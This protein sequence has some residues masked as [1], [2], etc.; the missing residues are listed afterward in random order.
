MTP[1]Q[2][3]NIISKYSGSHN[4]VICDLHSACSPL[5]GKKYMC[6]DI[7]SKKTV[8]DFDAVK[9]KADKER[10]IESRKSVDAVTNT[11]SGKYLCFIELKSWDL[12]LTNKGTENKIRK[13]ASKYE[14]DLPQKLT[15]SISICKQICKDESAF[16]NCKIVF[17]LVTDISVEKDGLADIQANLSALAGSSS[18]L[19]KLCNELSSKIMDDIQGVET[20]YWN[21][22]DLDSNLGKL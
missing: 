13:Q 7:G 4:S 10:G 20:R 9:T 22:R 5:K 6:G 3:Y 15:D 11:S 8:I 18:N 16:D 19:K 14:S 12:L 21:C 1:D 17:I 2:L